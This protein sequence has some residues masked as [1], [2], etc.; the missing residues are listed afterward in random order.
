MPPIGIML[1]AAVDLVYSHEN[2]E[3][4]ARSY[5]ENFTEI[6]VARVERGGD[7]F[8]RGLGVTSGNGKHFSGLHTYMTLGR[9]PGSV[10]VMGSDGAFLYGSPNLMDLIET[11]GGELPVGIAKSLYS[12]SGERFTVCAYPAFFGKYTVVGAIS[13]HDV[14]QSTMRFY[15]IWPYL[16]GFMG[17]WG[18][19]SIWKLWKL[20]LKPLEKLEQ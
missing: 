11:N 2:M 19:V 16:A 8:L 7:S 17:I 9:I 1:L 20:V 6:M 14:P 15:N 4:L 3:T 12:D 5:V 18:A 13:W 10:L